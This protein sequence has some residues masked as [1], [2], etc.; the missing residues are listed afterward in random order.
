[1]QVIIVP[2]LVTKPLLLTPNI[3]A[4][5]RHIQPTPIAILIPAAIEGIAEG[6]AI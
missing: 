5:T 3:S 2:Y 6:I 4:A 1:V